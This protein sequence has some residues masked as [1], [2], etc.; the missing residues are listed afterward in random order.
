M[1]KSNIINVNLFG[2]EIGRL[3][4][5]E[6]G[7]GTSFQYNP[8]YL[9][10]G[11][12]SNIFPK[13]GILKKI[14]Q[15]Q[16]FSAYNN[17]RF[18]G[19]PPQIA[20]SLPDQ[21]GSL[22]FKA[23]LDANSRK[24]ITVLEQLAY[25]SN[26]GM[27]AIEFVPGKELPKNIA[28]DIDEIIT[29]L[30]E[31]LAT[32]KSIRQKQFNTDALL[33]I[34]KIG[35]S[36]GGARPKILI[37]E[38]KKT[39]NIIPG[40]LEISNAYF[41]YVVKLALENKVDFPQEILEYCYYKVAKKIGIHMMD[42]KLIENKHFATERFDRQNGEKQHVLTATGLT[43][44]DFQ[45]PQHSSYE[46]LFK[47]SSFLKISQAQI[48]ELFT[49]MIFNVVFRN[50]DDHLKNHSFI[51]DKK[52]NNW[53][54][55]PAYDITYALNPLLDFKITNR[56]LSINNKRNDINL[57]DVL[58]IAENFTIK[59]PKGIIEKV[60]SGIPILK[61]LMK[62]YHIPKKISDIIMRNMVTLT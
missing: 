28:I 24:E 45:N 20:D 40:D 10:E 13:T 5:P 54:L 58:I 2:Q 44:W 6:N 57:N 43:G 52:R 41:H 36:A 42:S 31:V 15:V 53:K 32:K 48:E 22:I 61:K 4:I 7:I 18:H 34:F 14:P 12:Y 27:G 19:L 9:E 33:N 1:A 56:A 49:R 50:T 26:R 8:S 38:N 11:N 35:T 51:Y 62:E 23:W 37:S 60:Q 21:F 16:L 17:D 47:L 46:N 59:D 3:G 55:S 30:K 29:V 39:G 25:V